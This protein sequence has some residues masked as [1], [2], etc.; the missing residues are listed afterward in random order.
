MC[1]TSSV[2]MP[3]NLPK[4]PTPPEATGDGGGWGGN[5]RVSASEEA[6]LHALHALC[7]LDT[8][9]EPEFDDLVQ[10]AAAICGTPVSLISFVD[11]QRQWFKS[12][13]GLE[14]AETPRSVAFCHHTIEQPGLMLV[15]DAT[16]DPRFQTNPLVIGSTGWRFYAGMPLQGSDGHALGTLCVL[17]RVPRS[18]TPDQKTALR[19]LA[20]QVNASLD[21]RSKR[22]EL[23][24]ALSR[25]EAAKQR[26][27]AAE[28]RFRTFMDSGPFLAYI[29]SEEGRMLYYNQPMASQFSVSATALL[30]K[31]DAEL[32]LPELANTYRQHDLEV[33]RSGS[34]QVS[35]EQTYNPSGSISVWRSYKFPCS[36]PE[37]QLLLGGISVEV[38][39]E[40]QRQEELERYQVE[41]ETA[42]TRLQALASIDALTGLA[43]RRVFDE[44]LRRAFRSARHKGSPLSVLMIDVDRFKLHNDRF[45]H[46]HGD[47]VLRE[48]A[49]CLRSNLR[50]DDHLARYG[51]EE[52]VVLLPQT[53]AAEA[54]ALADRLLRA[55]R[56]HPWALAPVT[57]SVGL[58]TLNPA[59]RDT[60][61][62]MGRADEALYAAKCGGRDRVVAYADD[63]SLFTE[64]RKAS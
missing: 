41:L 15:E 27:E 34:L 21:L 22:R 36:G 8:P 3:A 55:I 46:S 17:D 57:V 25:A 56:R 35:H 9:P 48:L 39:Q 11:E 51:G 28:Q 43:N 49:A 12:S 54:R 38:T 7:I 20:H 32:W 2:A 6:R 47:D 59:T 62:L 26:A 19:T 44:Q 5:P 24:T 61:H 50:A 53:A 63:L 64:P 37:G 58:S 33:F 10:L 60:R 52:F 14:L 16:L 29:K 31:T 30:D 40:L 4:S 23:E 42:N 13:H 18:L 45:G 1:A